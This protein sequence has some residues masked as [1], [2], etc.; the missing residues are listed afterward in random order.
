LDHFPKAPSSFTFSINTLIVAG[1]RDAF[2]PRAVSEE[3][4]QANPAARLEIHEGATHYVPVEYPGRTVERPA[5]RS[6]DWRGSQGL[7]I[8][9][10]FLT[11]LSLPLSRF[12]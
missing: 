2:T 9:N 11:L 4:A 6:S 10:P 12:V 7:G 1:E 3:M 5:W 8:P